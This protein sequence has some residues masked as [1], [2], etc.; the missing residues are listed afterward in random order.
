[1]RVPKQPATDPH[2]LL[3]M[4]ATM[5]GSPVPR[6]VQWK[7]VVTEPPHTKR[8]MA[9]FAVMAAVGA[10]AWMAYSWAN[11]PQVAV[12]G[13]AHV[14]PV[15]AE[16]GADAGVQDVV[17]GLFATKM[18]AVFTVRERQ[19][20]AAGTVLNRLV[21]TETADG[22]GQLAIMVRKLP[23]GGMLQSSDIKHRQLY[24]DTYTPETFD[25]L[26][27]GAVAYRSNG[28]YELGI[29]M[30]RGSQY[31]SVVMSNTKTAALYDEWLRTVIDS[32]RWL[33]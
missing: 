19:D 33:P 13:T 12:L 15:P 28:T 30:A 8:R 17:M 11:R 1:M 20:I 31:V 29:F 4:P 10:G 22:S 7:M 26:P 18:P 21:A 6:K 16:P 2:A 23:D 24:S 3:H 25:W 5:A 9:V 14:Q 27:D 32:W